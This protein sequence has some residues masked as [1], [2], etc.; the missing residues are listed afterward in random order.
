M[1]KDPQQIEVGHCEEQ[2]ASVS[3]RSPVDQ[4]IA[5]QT[6]CQAAYQMCPQR[7]PGLDGNDGADKN[8]K[9]GESDRS[10]RVKATGQRWS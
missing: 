5:E 1:N 3:P 4:K 8:A 9:R 7:V 2:D 6:E 10:E